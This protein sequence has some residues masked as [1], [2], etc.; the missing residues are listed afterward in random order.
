MDKKN[1]S[2][3]TLDELVTCEKAAKSVILRYENN[4]KMYDGSIRTGG[5]DY[6]NYEKFNKIYLRIIDEMEKRISDL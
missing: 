6:V 2:N 4:I 1:I 3:L 5:E